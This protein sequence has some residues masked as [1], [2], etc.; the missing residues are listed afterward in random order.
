MLLLLRLLI[1][2]ELANLVFK[3]SDG[4]SVLVQLL[5][6]QLL[7]LKDLHLQLFAF[8]ILSLS[9]F[10]Y[11]FLF[12]VQFAL[13]I[14][15]AL[16]LLLIR[17]LIL[18]D[19]ALAL[20]HDLK[21]EVLHQTHGLLV[22]FVLGDHYIVVKAVADSFELLFESLRILEDVLYLKEALLS[23]ELLLCVLDPRI[24]TLYL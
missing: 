11:F 9:L 24:N 16:P 15:T 20:V 3:L 2:L 18:D 4:V 10:L 12:S 22:F 6:V 1:L 5:L 8:D 19:L 21:E 14:L 13:H 17:L 7:S 23:L